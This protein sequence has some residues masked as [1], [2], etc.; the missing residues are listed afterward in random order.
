MSGQAT[1]SRFTQSLLYE[2]RDYDWRGTGRPAGVSEKRDII[3]TW[4][5]EH[6][7]AKPKECMEATG[8]SRRTVYRYWK[9]KEDNTEES[10]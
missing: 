7:D 8:I 2:D 10:E 3:E 9:K 4:Q 1:I 5:A 6:P